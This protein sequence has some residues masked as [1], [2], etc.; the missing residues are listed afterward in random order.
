MTAKLLHH[1]EIRVEWMLDHCHKSQLQWLGYYPTT[2]NLN[3][4]ENKLKKIR[5]KKKKLKKI[6]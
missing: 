2:I 1:Q 4:I 3:I 5:Y 6:N